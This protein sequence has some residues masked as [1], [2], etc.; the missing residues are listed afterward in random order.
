MTIPDAATLAA[1]Q[2]RSICELTTMTPPTQ[3]LKTK[4]ATKTDAPSSPGPQD[5]DEDQPQALLN[6][7]MKPATT[8]HQAL[9]P[10]GDKTMTTTVRQFQALK[11]SR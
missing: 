6:L 5:D 4:T 3:S 7:K 8:P 11:F 9:G 10:R 1:A 2:G